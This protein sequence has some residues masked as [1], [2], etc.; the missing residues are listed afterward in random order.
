MKRR[1]SNKSKR[2]NQENIPPFNSEPLI[3][4]ENP[5]YFKEVREELRSIF[6]GNQKLTLEDLFPNPASDFDFK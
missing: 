5:G 2:S 3:C 1:I 6:L 4:I